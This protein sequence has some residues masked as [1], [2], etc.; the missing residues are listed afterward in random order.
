M[1]RLL[2]ERMLVEDPWL[3]LDATATEFDDRP[4]LFPLE[5]W[6]QHRHRLLERGPQRTGLWLDG[7]QEPEAL[8]G[9]LPG[10]GCIA[11]RFPAFMDGRGFS[12]ARL[13]R[14]RH[15]Y[16]GELRAIGDIIPD[17]LHYLWR[18]GFDAFELPEGVTLATA[19][20]C[21]DAFSTSYQ[22]TGTPARA[23]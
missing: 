19:L 5:I 12:C 8:A 23:R 18:C 1:P 2:K 20:R 16:R 3:R 11:I 22:Q 13:L 7:D 9:D 21:L 10:F 14:E 6:Q 17:Q 4:L 15:G